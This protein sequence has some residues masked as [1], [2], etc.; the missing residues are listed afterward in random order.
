VADE[1]IQS[2]VLTSYSHM[3][4]YQKGSLSQGQATLSGGWRAQ[5]ICLCFVCSMCMHSRMFYI[6]MIK[7]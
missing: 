7:R 1:R 5:Q 4:M 2:C 6:S 3:G